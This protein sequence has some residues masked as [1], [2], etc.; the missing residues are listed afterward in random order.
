MAEHRLQCESRA[1]PLLAG[2]VQS[3]TPG[4]HDNGGP[5]HVACVRRLSRVWHF[6]SLVVKP[7]SFGRDTKSRWSFLSDV[8]ARG[9]K[10]SHT[11]GKC[12]TL[13]D[14]EKFS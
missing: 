5:V 1:M 14:S 9:S 10:R 2:C 11:E 12:V 6:P 3:V 13:V 4:E 7:V 8:Y